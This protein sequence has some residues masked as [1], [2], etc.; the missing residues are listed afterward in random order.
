MTGNV[1]VSINPLPTAYNVTGG[2]AYCS[3]GSRYACRSEQLPVRI[4][5]ASAQWSGRGNRPGNGFIPDLRNL[6]NA[7]TYRVLATNATTT[8]TNSMTGNV[9]VSINPLPTA[10]NVTGGGAYCSGGAGMPVGLSNSQSGVN[11]Q[12]QLNGVLRFDRPGNG[13]IPDLRGPD[14]CRHI[15]CQSHK[16]HNHLHKQ[17]DRQCNS[18]NKPIAHSI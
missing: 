5:S 1:T 2:G 9:T 7:G 3:G 6:T 12:L 15:Y 18:N 14:K 8:C 10:Y 17:H 13:F 4:L 16:C 11:Y